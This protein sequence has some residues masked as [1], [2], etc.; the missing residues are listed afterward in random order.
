[1]PLREFLAKEEWAVYRVDVKK[2][3]YFGDTFFG[4]MWKDLPEEVVV[5]EDLDLDSF[6][7]LQNYISG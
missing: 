3:R 4:P 7:S 5:P 2:R 1:M 6:R